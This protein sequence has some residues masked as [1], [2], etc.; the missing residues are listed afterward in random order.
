MI[1][2]FDSYI[3]RKYKNVN[4]R[5]LKQI[6]KN[7]A[8]HKLSFLKFLSKEDF[9]DDYMNKIIKC[10]RNKFYIFSFHGEN[11]DFDRDTCVGCIVLRE[12]YN[13]EKMKRYAIPLLSIHKDI[14]GLGYGKLLLDQLFR[15]IKERNNKK[16]EIVLHS[17]PKS[18]KFYLNY[19]F[20]SIERNKFLE[21]VEEIREGDV[22]LK[23]EI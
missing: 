20:L 17:L 22:L 4:K 12:I 6:K 1:L 23:Y 8:K 2:D 21:R 16:I 18:V 11:Q 10:K 3:E 5:N 14:R 19:G 9:E 15:T 7:K 13:G